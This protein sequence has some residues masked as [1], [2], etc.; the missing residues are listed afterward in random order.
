LACQKEHIST[1]F[2]TFNEINSKIK[3]TLEEEKH[4]T[5]PFLDMELTRY[6]TAVY[7]NWFSKPISSNRIL[8]FYSYHPYNMKYNIA[9]SFAKRVIILSHPNY[10]YENLR[11][12][13]NIL[14]K[15]NYP[16]HIINKILKNLKYTKTTNNKI[17]S[18][19]E[20]RLE[21]TQTIY[22][23]MTY[24][25]HIS[26]GLKRKIQKEDKNLKISFKPMN[27]VKQH[28]TKIKDSVKKAD[29]SNIVY[30]VNCECGVNYI[31]Q[32]KRKLTKRIDEHKKYVELKSPKSGLA[33]HAI[34]NNHTFKFDDIKILT[35]ERNTK[36]REIKES[37]E[38]F[39]NKHITANIKRDTEKI[40]KV[41]HQIIK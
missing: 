19:P 20:I 8:N 28:F 26:E 32:T 9:N 15:N 22:K 30:Q 4:Q 13:D 27:K 7:T 23:S 10:K 41:Y 1:V 38:I 21:D 34:E 6:G 18:N 5:I 31:G 3:F 2:N 17:P 37:I 12:I 14:T 36:K 39:K 11:K 16:K 29:K 24:I 25:P 40:K 35:T 33:A